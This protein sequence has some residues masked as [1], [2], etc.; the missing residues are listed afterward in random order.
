MC[1]AE[2][3]ARAQVHFVIV[4]GLLACL[5]EGDLCVLRKL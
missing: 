4:E 1:I 5:F 3:E 2:I